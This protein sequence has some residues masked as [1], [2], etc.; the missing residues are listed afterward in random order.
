MNLETE[1]QMDAFRAPPVEPELSPGEPVRSE[2]KKRGR[3]PKYPEG[4]KRPHRKTATSAPAPTAKPADD[5][6]V[7]V[8]VPGLEASDGEAR[9]MKLSKREAQ[10][11]LDQ[12]FSMPA[13]MLEPAIFGCMLIPGRVATVKVDE[14]E[15]FDVQ[16]PE[17]LSVTRQG[18]IQGIAVLVDGVE[19]DPRWV[20][21]G[22]VAVHAASLG[23][24]YWQIASEIKKRRKAKEEGAAGQGEGQHAGG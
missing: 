22:M 7:K 24:V 6:A 21:A 5:G 23:A 10:E 9:P 15:T 4:Y 8:E 11:L 3:P 20:A 12:V 2:P 18:A 16:I 13:S 17:H 19:L 14:E 1:P